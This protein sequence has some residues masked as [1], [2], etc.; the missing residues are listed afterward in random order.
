MSLGFFSV[1]HLFCFMYYFGLLDLLIDR[2][3]VERQ[4]MGRQR[5]E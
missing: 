4:E 1:S 3:D 5:G 2:T